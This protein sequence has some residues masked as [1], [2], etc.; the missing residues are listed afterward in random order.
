[1]SCL[2]QVGDAVSYIETGTLQTASPGALVERLAGR[3]E[4]GVVYTAWGPTR[5]TVRIRPR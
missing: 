2:D 1:V 3:V 5:A 4:A